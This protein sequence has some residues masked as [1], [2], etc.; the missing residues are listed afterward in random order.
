MPE[1]LTAMRRK[2][3][4]IREKS[5][6]E[7][8]IRAAT[9]CRL[10]M[11]D[12]LQPYIVP[13]CF[14]YREGIFYFHSADTGRKLELLRRNNRVCFELDVDC[15]VLPGEKACHWSMAYKS[16]IGFGR[17]EFIEDPFDKR[18][19]L[20][21]IM[22]QYAAKEDEFDF[23]DTQLRHTAVF[24]VRVECLTGKQSG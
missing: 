23:D 2:D 10:A 5:E 4:E 24:R 3:K 12:G 20:K 17:A 21:V 9:V 11:V 7:A 22:R 6:T 13:L 15:R 14:G 1:D 16:V 19:A 18:R 8:V